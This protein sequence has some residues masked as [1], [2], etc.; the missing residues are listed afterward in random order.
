M[1]TYKTKAIILSSYPYREHDRIISFFS[2]S[3]GRIEA[4]ARGIRKIQSK[5]AGHLEP[6][7]ETELLLANGRRWDI[8]AGSRTINAN[9]AIRQDFERTAAASVCVEAVKRITKPLS[10]E[11]GLYELLRSILHKLEKEDLSAR[12][13][14]LTVKFLWHLVSLSGFAPEL[15][16]CINCKKESKTGSFSYE[17]GGILCQNCANRDVFAASVNQDIL[18]QLKERHQTL[19]LETQNIITTF[20]NRIIEAPLGSWNFFQ[21]VYK[22]PH[23]ENKS[24]G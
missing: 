5:L 12:K 4:R 22:S 21:E 15:D 3:F 2:D 1:A 11:H 10:R 16:H 7:I 20:W 9:A 8:L 23:L 6:F 19:A 24:A 17:G 18:N 13:Q 14:E